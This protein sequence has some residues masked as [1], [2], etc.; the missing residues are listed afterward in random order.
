MSLILCIETGTDVCSVA[1]SLNGKPVSLR[2]ETGRDHARKVAVFTDELL[3]EASVD[4]DE[5][6]AIAVG[7]GPGSYT[8]LRIGA[9]FA[10]GLCYALNIPLI[11]VDSLLS[12]AV[13]ACENHEAG[14]TPAV[15]WDSSR[16]CPMIDARRMEV[17]AEVFDT[18]L[19]RLSDVAAEVLE[20]ESF[21]GFIEPGS[22]LFIFGN[23]AEKSAAILPSKGVRLIEVVPSARGLCVPAQKM[24]DAGQIVDTAYFEPSYL[25]DFIV[26]ASR[27]KIF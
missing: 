10:K 24:L 3:K 7:K 1:L 16:L 17:Y 13:I 25:K 2:E 8:G 20:P 15:C 4:P 12:L 9:S 14:L 23:G 22:E 21:A 5:L 27:K 26:T 18:S 6:D 19:N 11:A